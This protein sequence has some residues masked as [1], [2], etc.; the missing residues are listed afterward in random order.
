MED[1]WEAR[2]QPPNNRQQEIAMHK[3]K[4]AIL[5]LAILGLI[6]VPQAL[7]VD[8]VLKATIQSVTEKTG[9]DGNPFIRF[10]INEDRSK[11]INGV[12]TPYTVGV[13]VMCFGSLVDEARNLSQGDQLHAI[14]Q[15]REWQGRT[16]YVVFKFLE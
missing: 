8:T 10:I 15:S 6:A 13:A 4:V 5:T 7:A 14:A 1:T 16:S 11:T 2:S 3:L 12:V 9:Q